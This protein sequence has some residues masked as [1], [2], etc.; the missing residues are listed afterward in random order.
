MRIYIFSCGVDKNQMRRVSDYVCQTCVC[1]WTNSSG[2]EKGLEG[3]QE[4][5]ERLRA[6]GGTELVEV[7]FS[8]SVL[9]KCRLG[10]CCL[11]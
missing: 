3:Q 6:E 2:A 8:F 7:F 5:K 4:S 9:I 10:T 11:N 1:R